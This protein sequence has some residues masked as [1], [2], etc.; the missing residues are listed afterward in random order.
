MITLGLDYGTT[1]N[2]IVAFDDKQ[3]DK[4]L[5]YSQA[6]HAALTGLP[7]GHAEQSPAVVWQS[8]LDLLA[9]LP[10]DIRRQTQ[11]IGLTGQ[12]H[13]AMLW[14]DDGAAS[15][16]ITWQD[17]RASADG[18]LRHFRRISPRLAD[19]FGFTTLAWL[20]QNN[21]LD[22]WDHAG[23]PLS[24][25]ALQLTGEKQPTIDH[26]FAASWG[27]WDI[28]RADWDHQAI[29]DLGIPE[30]LLPALVPPGSLI[31]HTRNVPGLPD[32]LPV[33]AAFGDNQASVLGTARDLDREIYLTLGTGAQL[34]MVINDKERQ[35][36]P[37]DWTGEIRP[38]LNGAF[39][40]VNAPLCGGRAWAWLGEAVNSILSALSLPTIPEGEILDRLDSLALQAEP[41]GLVFS[42]CFLGERGKPDATA[43]ITGLRLDNFSLSAL[44]RS[45]AQGIVKQLF[46]PFPEDLRL[47][48]QLVV[49]SGNGVR[50]CRSIQQEITSQSGLP[51]ELRQ[52]PEEAATGAACLAASS[53]CENGLGD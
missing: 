46:A 41:N 35:A 53:L 28:N 52:T 34:S 10:A 40:A 1:K 23:C 43:E 48:R 19:G 21:G 5:H 31:G 13:S 17:R 30:R 38:F 6:H 9:Q 4:S 8:F 2:A 33:F 51:L 37:P 20:V 7:A 27:L 25:L 39:L 32:S 29:S 18:S 36:F 42:P 15:P 47:Q 16:V 22:A 49:G 44:A 12:M 26:T 3:P 11:A 14:R 50:L 24:W 45:L